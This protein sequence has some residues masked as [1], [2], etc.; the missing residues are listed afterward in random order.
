MLQ[1]DTLKKR[2]EKARERKANLG[3]DI[4]IEEL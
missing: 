3:K 4:E 2:A 1:S